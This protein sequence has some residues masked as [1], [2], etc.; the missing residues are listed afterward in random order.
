MRIGSLPH[1][2]AIETPAAA[3]RKGEES[4]TGSASVALSKDAQFVDALTQ[5]A[6]VPGV[7]QDVVAQVRSELADG[8]FDANTNLDRVVEGLLADL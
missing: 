3:P 4:P 6:D 7:R 2:Q 1:I 8:T 5:H